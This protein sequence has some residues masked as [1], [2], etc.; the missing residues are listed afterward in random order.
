MVNVSS[1]VGCQI[2]AG[3]IE[4]IRRSDN[5]VAI[6]VERDIVVVDILKK[7]LVF[8]E[9]D[10]SYILLPTDVGRFRDT[11]KRLVVSLGRVSSP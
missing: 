10:V 11:F 9:E 6:L 8:D 1:S 5:I 2:F 4:I 3:C 7:H